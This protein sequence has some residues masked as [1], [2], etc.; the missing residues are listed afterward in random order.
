MRQFYQKSSVVSAVTTIFCIQL[1]EWYTKQKLSFLLSSFW[2]YVPIHL[3]YDSNKKYLIVLSYTLFC[4]LAV[5][6][7]WH[8][9]SAITCYLIGC[10]HHCISPLSVTQL[11]LCQSLVS[12]SVISVSVH[13]QSLS[14]HCVSPCQ[15]LSHQCVSPFSVTQSS[16]CQSI[17]SHSVITVSVLCQSQAYKSND[18]IFWKAG[19]SLTVSLY[20]TFGYCA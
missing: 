3:N 9:K 4:Y 2:R 1:S 17:V 20:S 16:L 6:W 12:H 14:H 11:S 15:S 8:A 19:I 7:N 5:V 10:S 18:L 13:C